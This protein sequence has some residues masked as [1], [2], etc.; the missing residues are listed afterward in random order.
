MPAI[1][2]QQHD[3][4]RTV[5]NVLAVGANPDDVEFLCAGTLAAFARRGDRVSIAYLT[6]GDKGSASLP[7]EEIAGIR[8][9]EAQSAAALI[10][11]ELHALG[12]PDGEVVV[13]LELRRRVVEVIRAARPDIIITHHPHDYMSD[14]NCTSRLVF[15]ASFWAGSRHFEGDPGRLPPCER[16]PPL[17]YM[18]TVGGIGFIPQEYVD[19]T[20]VMEVKIAMLSQHQS[21]IRYMK[22]RDGLDFLDCMRTAARYRGFQCGVACA[23]GFIPERVYPSCSPRRLLP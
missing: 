23:E 10:G 15:D 20:E 5:M 3:M 18:D 2:M 14:H 12:L 8:Q 4:R 11:A 21:Q 1:V 9:K 7:P 22:E 17:Y 16:R 19:I 6:Q 13:S